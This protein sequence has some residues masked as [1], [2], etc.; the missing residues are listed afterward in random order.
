[1]DDNSLNWKTFKI[2]HGKSTRPLKKT[3]RPRSQ[4]EKKEMEEEAKK[5]AMMEIFKDRFGF[6]EFKDLYVDELYRSIDI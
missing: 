4:E 5:A 2:Y 3:R 6:T 1:M